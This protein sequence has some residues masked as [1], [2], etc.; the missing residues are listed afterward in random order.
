M[1]T[2]AVSSIALGFPLA[3]DRGTSCARPRFEGPTELV[4]TLARRTPPEAARFL[5]DEIE[6]REGRDGSTDPQEPPAFPPRQ[7]R[8]SVEPCRS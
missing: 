2:I 6:R 1:S 4:E 3:E 7:R 8:I 5:L